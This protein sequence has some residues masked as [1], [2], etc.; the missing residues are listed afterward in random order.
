MDDITTFDH[1]T[2]RFDH[3]LT[4]C[5]QLA[6]ML[7]GSFHVFCAPSGLWVGWFEH[8][9]H[10]SCWVHESDLCKIRTAERSRD[11]LREKA[12]VAGYSPALLDSYHCW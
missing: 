1:E 4:E 11:K 5:Q 6:A 7:G 3:L 10:G 8:S 9:A 12:V 2:L